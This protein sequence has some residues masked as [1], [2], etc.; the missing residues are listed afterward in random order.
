[1]SNR[2]NFLNFENFSD[3]K[4]FLKKYSYTKIGTASPIS[5]LSYINKL[6]ALA[7]S[8]HD[9]FVKRVISSLKTTPINQISNR[10]ANL[11]Q[12]I[13]SQNIKSKITKNQKR[14]KN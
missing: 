4:N 5:L 6:E 2:K 11:E 14:K 13:E 3:L 10:L 12:Y 1:M 9:P 8:C 7:S